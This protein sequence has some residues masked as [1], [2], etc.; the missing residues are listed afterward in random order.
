[1]R[2]SGGA[3]MEC[4]GRTCLLLCEL[5]VDVGGPYLVAALAAAKRKRLAFG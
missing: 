3:A 2:P 1:M 4:S 5:N